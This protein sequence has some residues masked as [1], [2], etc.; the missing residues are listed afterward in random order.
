M[1]VLKWRGNKFFST[2]KADNGVIPVNYQTE[3]KCLGSSFKVLFGQAKTYKWVL[4]Q[5]E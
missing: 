1:I 3:S 4:S 2:G 5:T